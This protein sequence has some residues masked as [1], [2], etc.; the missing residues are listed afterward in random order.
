MLNID[1][2]LLYCVSIH[3]YLPSEHNTCF[4]RLCNECCRLFEIFLV[5]LGESLQDRIDLL[6]K[7][8]NFF[9]YCYAC[10]LYLLVFE[11]L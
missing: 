3:V 4:E 8:N 10:N 6:T 11:S 5:P 7:G 9:I 1:S 2:V